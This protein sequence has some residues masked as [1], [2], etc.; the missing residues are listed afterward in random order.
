[1]RLTGQML[2]MGIVMLIFA[3][4]MGGTALTPQTAPRFLASGR[5]A[6]SVFAALCLLG[7]FASLARG[8]IRAQPA[9]VVQS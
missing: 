7:V 3:L 8:N 5:V 4:F 6:F 1:M 9:P 2:S